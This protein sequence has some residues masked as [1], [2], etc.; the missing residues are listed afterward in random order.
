M[1]STSRVLLVSIPVK[2]WIKGVITLCYAKRHWETGTPIN[3]WITT[4]TTNSVTVLPLCIVGI[5]GIE[6]ALPHIRGRHN[7]LSWSSRFS[8]SK[9]DLAGRFWEEA[10]A[11]KI[12]Q[13]SL[14]TV[15]TRACFGSAQGIA[16]NWRIAVPHPV[17]ACFHSVEISQASYGLQFTFITTCSLSSWFLT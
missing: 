7:F 6:T 10:E 4:N 5:R 14:L 13:I 11:G 1:T 15:S 12:Q 16:K 8:R 17:S 9:L 3:E 2:W